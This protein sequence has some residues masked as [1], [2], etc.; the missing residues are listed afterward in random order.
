MRK[1]TVIKEKSL[2]ASVIAMVIIVALFIMTYV[3]IS[4]IIEERCLKRM[5]EGVDT[6]IGEIS[7][8]VTRD[9]YLL[10]ATADILSHAE[11]FDEKAMEESIITLS[12]LM[13]TMQ[14]RILLPDDTVIDTSGDALK[15]ADLSF[16][17]LEPL[18]E[19]LS[20]REISV[21]DGNTLVLRH[22]VPIIKNGETVAILYGVTI[23]SDLPSIMNVSNIYDANASSYIIDMETG[24]FIMDTWHETPGNLYEFEVHKTKGNTS[25]EEAQEEMLEGKT[26]YMVYKSQTSGQWLYMYYAPAGIN[27]WTI[28]VSVPEEQAF[29]LLFSIRRVLWLVAAFI[30]VTLISYYVWVRNNAEETM[31]R[32]VEKAVLE[33][34]LQKA[35]AAEKAKTMFLSNM[36][37]DIRTPMNAIIGFTTLAQTNINNTERVQEYLVK[38]LS[39]GNHLLSLINDVLDMSRI[40]SGRLNIAEKEC[41]ISDIFRDMRNIMQTQMKDKQLNFFMDTIDV[42]D[43]EIYCDKLHINQVL[44]NLLSNA[45]KFTPAGGSISLII[46]QKFGAPEGYGAYE[47]RV[48]DTGIGMHPDFVEH[49]FEPFERERNSTTSGIQGTG[50][51][52]AITKSIVDAMG[53]TIEVHTEQGK[54]TEFV[55][56][57]EFR[58]QK[59]RKQMEV[60]QELEGLRTLVVDD[61]FNACDSIAKMLRQI[62][63]RSEWTMHGREAV[64]RARQAREMEDEF[65][66]YI[67]DWVLPDLSGVEVVKQLRAAIGDETPI[68]ILSAYDWRDIEEEAKEA[69][70]TAFCSKPIFIS[71]LR[72]TMASLLNKE[73]V[74]VSAKEDSVLPETE[75]EFKGSRFLLVE[76]N[77]LNREIA[78]ELLRESG[79]L[80]ESVEDGSFAVEV[81]KNATP[82]YY[83]L[84]LMDIQMPVM[85]GY[86]ATKAIRKLDNPA[87]AN[88]PIIAMTANAFDEDKRMALESG[89]NAHVAKPIDL[90]VLMEAIYAELHKSVKSEI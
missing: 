48:K 72:D 25:W 22:Y 14:V 53:G 20:G 16:K 15:S 51:G 30:A 7:R 75:E 21:K 57:F 10:N 40:E 63:M 65:Y 56:N 77:V 3:W 31:K 82:G 2:T 74:R 39:S 59:E 73:D 4:A 34:K 26:G 35:E 13:E 28:A 27:H 71:E 64:L 58:L 55:I 12:A 76:D 86:E 5:E 37:H 18:G 61:D 81:I 68:I 83:D 23:L 60:I 66:A 43:E 50:L 87:L 80:V 67:I 62:G 47:I 88:I 24:D 44:L 54:G 36:S 42:I 85:N 8:K 33:E 46:K 1:R 19:H 11:N 84:I 32:V 9:S 45:I 6:V 79:F 52:M 49:I 70:V 17:E 89:M 29:V 69:G 90:P 38:I 41:K 78:E